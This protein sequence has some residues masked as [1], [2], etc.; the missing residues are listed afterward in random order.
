MVRARARATPNRGRTHSGLTVGKVVNRSTRAARKNT[1][2]RTIGPKSHKK[3]CL[4]TIVS[5]VSREES[6][7][8]PACGLLHGSLY[9][10]NL[11]PSR[12]YSITKAGTWRTNKSCRRFEAAR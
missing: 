3:H 2:T 5:G 11:F 1:S 12:Q 9:F 8:N 4:G 6:T 10:G 7:G